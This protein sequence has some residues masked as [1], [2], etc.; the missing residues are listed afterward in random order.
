MS[1]IVARCYVLAEEVKERWLKEE[2]EKARKKVKKT[3]KVH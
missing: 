2:L 1:A 3:L